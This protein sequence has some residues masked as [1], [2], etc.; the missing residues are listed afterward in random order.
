MM[1]NMPGICDKYWPGQWY[2]VMPRSGT[3]LNV[4]LRHA[5]S[6]VREAVEMCFQDNHDVQGCPVPKLQELKAVPGRSAL[7]VSSLSPEAP[8]QASYAMGYNLAIEYLA[9]YEKVW[10]LDSFRQLDARVLAPNG[11]PLSQWLFLEVRS[12]KHLA[13][14]VPLPHH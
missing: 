4:H 3:R 6:L 10:M 13:P 11:R 5:R 12:C 14:G 7:E 9:D 2:P 1:W 8:V